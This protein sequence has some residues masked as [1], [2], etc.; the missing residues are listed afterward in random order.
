[1]RVPAAGTSTLVIALWRGILSS[2]VLTL[3]GWVAFNLP[4][5]VTALGG[6]LL[7]GL[8][9]VHVYVLTVEPDL[10]PS[11][12]AY[13]AVLTAG[14]LIAQ[15]AMVFSAKPIGPQAG[16][17]LGSLMCLAFLSTYLISRLVTLSR[18]EAVTGRWDFAPGTFAM[19]FA[20]GFVAV[21]MTVLSG[22]NVAY[23]Q[24]QGW[25]D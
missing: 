18:L 11:F 3:N 21:H 10:P 6:S 9:V 19:A 13:S 8:V 20:A 1:M 15:G 4:R 12:F 22:I 14:C 5:T 17:Y 16:W 2:P 24:Q 23:P 7:M 25:R